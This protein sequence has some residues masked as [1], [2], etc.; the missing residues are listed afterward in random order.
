M[1]LHVLRSD[2]GLELVVLRAL[3][4]SLEVCS[5]V[6]DTSGILIGV[7]ESW[8][9]F[10]GKNPFL[11]GQAVGAS[12]A[13]LCKSLSES[14]AGD[15]SIVAMGITGVMK[16]AVPR[17]ALDYP[18]AE[19]D[20]VHEYA[21]TAV[22]P[23]GMP[24]VSAVIHIRDITERSARERRI[25]RSERLFKATTDNAMDL[26][27]LL[28]SSGRI[29]YHNPALQRLLGWPDQQIAEKSMQDLVH[30]DDLGRFGEALH[31]GVKAGLTQVFDYRITNPH[32]GW[33]DL[34]GQV[35]AVDDPGG[36]GESILLISRDISSR[37]Q[38]ER[39]RAQV[40]IQLRHSQKLEAI[41]QLAAGIAHEINTP[42]Q[43]IGDNTA[44]LRD[45]F[46][47]T[48]GM[49][50]T[51]ESHLQSIRAGGGAAAAEATKAL[52]ALEE[53]DLGY[54]EEEIP[55]AIQ[56]SLE[57]VGRVTSIVGAMKDFSRPSGETL[58]HNDLH[59]AIESTIAVSRG[60]W[61]A[62]AEV[63]TEFAPNLPLVPCFPGEINQV[64]LN[65]IVNAAHA[66]KGREGK[67]GASQPGRIRIGTRIAGPE[68]EISVSD[69]GTGIPP[70]IQGRIFDPFFT[71]KPVGM[72]SGQGLSIVHGV[73]TE[74]H[75]GRIELESAL[76]V[77]T[78]FRI[79]LPL[80]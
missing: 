21:C 39:E 19:A 52:S 1:N 74:K 69:N 20:G 11:A 56:E 27:C 31:K 29:I 67:G 72:G 36:H 70:E 24:G 32:G 30:K 18:V 43:Y 77:G 51:L 61:K 6:A 54:L 3:T 35:S 25:R 41:G 49:V 9:A 62:V 45:A 33:I 79:F 17:L 78:T 23:A 44:F 37:K 22:H 26:I 66:I 57:G 64:I 10:Q 80:A 50:R 42:T 47:Q 76:G 40:E 58:S 73:I 7:T 68:V 48:V 63:E 34:E 28:D 16:G 2:P 75:K 8:A 53:G 46:K 38:S 15:L 5:A 71:T 55:K 60:E 4:R 65:L 12:Y 14:S 59:K 13:D